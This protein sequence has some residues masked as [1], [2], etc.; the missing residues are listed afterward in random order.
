[1]NTAYFDTSAVVKLLVEEP[2]TE[3]AAAA[4]RAADE[5]VASG[6]LY[7]EARAALAAARRGGRLNVKQLG[8]ARDLLE[9]VWDQL[10]VVNAGPEI[11]QMAGD[12]AELEALRGFDAVHLAS[13]LTAEVDLLVSSDGQMLAAARN[14]GLAVLNPDPIA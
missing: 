9:Q 11:L 12:L 6:L 13:A 4:W 3:L 2:G 1:M 5:V 7:P 14:R 10:A 8:S